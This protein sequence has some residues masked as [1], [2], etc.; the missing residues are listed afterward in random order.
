MGGGADGV[1]EGGAEGRREPTQS[2]AFGPAG[3]SGTAPAYHESASS[4]AFPPSREERVPHSESSH[5][6]SA[7]RESGAASEPA[8]PAEPRPPE[9]PFV[10]WSSAPS[11]SPPVRRDE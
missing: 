5:E 4:A 1:G 6:P 11:D 8:R 10:V 3:S 7:A 2:D 9:K